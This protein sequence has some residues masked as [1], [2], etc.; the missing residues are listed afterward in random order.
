M[1]GEDAPPL[2]EI[3]LGAVGAYADVDMPEFYPEDLG[4]EA[5]PGSKGSVH[6]SFSSRWLRRDLLPEPVAEG[7]REHGEMP[8]LAQALKARAS[9]QARLD[10]MIREKMSA[11]PEESAGIR[12]GC[13]GGK[14]QGASATPGVLLSMLEQAEVGA[15]RARKQGTKNQEAIQ[16]DKGPCLTVEVGTPRNFNRIRAG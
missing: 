7:Q 11:A 9:E 4:R 12:G 14:R 13:G 16:I 1:G 6:P 3:L 10:D 5:L 15:G 8:L 2:Y